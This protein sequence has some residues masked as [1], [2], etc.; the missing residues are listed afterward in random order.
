MLISQ[1]SLDAKCSKEQNNLESKVC[2][3]L[4]ENNEKEFSKDWQLKKETN[5]VQIFLP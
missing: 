5:F 3:S 1:V 2:I 4:L